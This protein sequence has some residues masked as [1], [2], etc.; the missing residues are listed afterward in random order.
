MEAVCRYRSRLPRRL[1]AFG[2]L[3][4]SSVFLIVGIG[5]ATP[6]RATRAALNPEFVAYQ[7]AV[8]N[9]ALPRAATEDGHTLGLVPSPLDLSHMTGLSVLEPEPKG[10][11]AFSAQYDLRTLG[12]LTAVRDQGACGSCWSFAAMSSLESW[13]LTTPVETWDFSENNLKEC[14]G[15]DWSPCAGGNNTIAM[16]YFARQRGPIGEA[17]D[18]YRAYAVGCTSGLTVR[19]TVRDVLLPPDRGGFLDNDTIKQ[20]VITYGAISTDLHWAD[21]SY[22]SANHSFYYSG[23]AASNHGVAIVG[24]NDNYSR[25]LF[26]STPS[27]DGAWI[28]RNSWGASF[29]ENGYFYVS[30]YDTKIG[31]GNAAFVNAVNPSTSTVYQYDPLGWVT[32]WGYGSTTAWGANVFTATADGSIASVGTYASTVNTSYQIEI[33]SS[34]SGSVLATK[35][36]VWPFAGYH[37]VDLDVPVAVTSGQTFAVVVR[38]T[39]PG[40][41]YPIPAECY[42]AGYSSGAAAGAEQSYIS[43]DGNSW[44]DIVTVWWGDSTCNVCI[45]AIVAE[46]PAAV[47]FSVT[48]T[49]D[50]HAGGAL[51]GSAFLAG[52]ADVAEWVSVSEPVEAGDVLEFDPAH[53]GQYRKSNGACSVLVAG[54]VSQSPGITL[55][56]GL[57]SK[58]RALL[59][60]VGIVPVKVTDEGGP[61]AAGDLLVASSTP[62]Y[63]MRWDP[64]SAKPCGLVGKALLGMSDANGVILAILMK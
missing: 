8:E 35:T 5:S 42:E 41:N 21:S 46:Q 28:V 30:Y 43:S 4:L 7:E 62:G 49:G 12:R 6:S 26:T 14:H 13:L 36:G 34:L 2:I 27:G 25:T 37:T 20:A 1:L 45:K 47:A 56:T 63:A 50:V 9:M 38:Y 60:L 59:A 10:P 17:D 64:G 61:I 44:T 31:S 11:L 53:P 3:A 22:S 19:K 39:T 40:Y 29:G 32:N 18:P 24:W 48:G 15:F 55:G 33:R 58:A 51:Y 52:S 23:S 16:A 54:V 57:E